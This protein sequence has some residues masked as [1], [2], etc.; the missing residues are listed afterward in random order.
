M[1]TL[2]AFQSENAQSSKSQ[3]VFRARF[4]KSFRR[5]AERI[6]LAVAVSHSRCHLRPSKKFWRL[7]P[8]V[9][10][11]LSLSLWPCSLPLQTL[12]HIYDAAC[13]LVCDVVRARF[14][15]QSRRRSSKCERADLPL[16]LTAKSREICK[17]GRRCDA[18]M[19][20]DVDISKQ[21]CPAFLWH[22][23]RQ[24]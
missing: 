14:R 24:L 16:A 22:V 4:T 5:F 15:Q 1:L 13:C 6:A 21:A 2:S 19:H 7:R 3:S 9:V 8:Q 11:N 12:A 17:S 20:A 10:V 18:Q 23:R